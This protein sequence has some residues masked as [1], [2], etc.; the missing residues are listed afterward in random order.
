MCRHKRL[1]FGRSDLHPAGWWRAGDGMMLVVS[2]AETTVGQQVLEHGEEVM[3]KYE[4]INS[5][6]LLC[7]LAT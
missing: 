2:D 3:Q 6:N 1:A 5:I 4:K 7:Y